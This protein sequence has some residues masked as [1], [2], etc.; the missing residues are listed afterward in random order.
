MLKELVHLVQNASPQRVGNPVTQD[1]QEAHLVTRCIHRSSDRLAVGGGSVEPGLQVDDGNFAHS[2]PMFSDY[3]GSKT[4]R[5]R[6]ARRCHGLKT[7][8]R[9]N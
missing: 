5:M 9:A 8:E 7:C 4:K 1:L 6:E 2:A 3:E